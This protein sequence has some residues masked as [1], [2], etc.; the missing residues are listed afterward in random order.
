MFMKPTQIFWT[1]L[2]IKCSLVRRNG[3]KCFMKPAAGWNGAN[4]YLTDVLR[5]RVE[6][7][8]GGTPAWGRGRAASDSAAR[9]LGCRRCTSTASGRP[10]TSSQCAAI[11]ISRHALLT[12]DAINT[13]THIQSSTHSLIQTPISEIPD[14]LPGTSCLGP[15]VGDLLLESEDHVLDIA[16]R[17]HHVDL[18]HQL[19]RLPIHR[20][21]M[22]ESST[23]QQLPA[24]PENYIGTRHAA[25]SCGPN[26][27]SYCIIYYS[28][29]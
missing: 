4:W 17:F 14:I 24:T 27:Y 18:A 15:S 29:L 2:V 13:H 6:S 25:H 1:A 26:T 5:R 3:I 23:N 12:T 10:R 16:N 11:C 9:C 20:R 22:A 7:G 19:L 28:N 8:R 21:H